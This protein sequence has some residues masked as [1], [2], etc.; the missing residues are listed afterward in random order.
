VCYVC[1]LG[2]ASVLPGRLEPKCLASVLPGR[3]EAS[4][5]VAC[6]VRG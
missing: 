3:L 4:V 5:C 2:L 6:A 1:G